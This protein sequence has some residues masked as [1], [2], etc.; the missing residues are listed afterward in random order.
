MEVFLLTGPYP[1]THQRG[2]GIEVGKIG[3]FSPREET[4]SKNLDFFLSPIGVKMVVSSLKLRNLP[5]LATALKFNTIV[6]FF[7]SF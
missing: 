4:K 5:P 2:G 7:F 6:F 3:L 1:A